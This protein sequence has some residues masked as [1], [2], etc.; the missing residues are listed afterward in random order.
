MCYSGNMNDKVINVYKKCGET[1]LDCINKLKNDDSNL[2]FLPMTYAGRLDPLAEGV[3]FIL[4][5]DECHKKD[6]YLSLGKVYEV[7]ILF[8][9][10]TDTYDVMGVFTKTEELFDFLWSGPSSSLVRGPYEEE[11]CSFQI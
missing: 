1:P 6:E 3:L 2:R 9:F 7:D 4:I 8:G 11:L 10:A 5:G